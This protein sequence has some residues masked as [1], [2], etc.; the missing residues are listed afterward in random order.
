LE[1]P[2]NGRHVGRFAFARAD[3][4]RAH[5]KHRKML[6]VGKPFGRTPEEK[7]KPLSG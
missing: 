5:A 7:Q 3:G 2:S 6:G 4:T 1:S